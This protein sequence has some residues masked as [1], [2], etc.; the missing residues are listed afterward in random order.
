MEAVPECTE[1]S[2]NILISTSLQA[3]EHGYDYFMCL[4]VEKVDDMIGNISRLM[5]IGAQSNGKPRRTTYQ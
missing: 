2:E 4:E 1:K 5:K 3:Q